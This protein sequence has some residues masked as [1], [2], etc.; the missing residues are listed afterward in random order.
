[1]LGFQW[2]DR[3]GASGDCWEVFKTKPWDV[4]A[5]V[6]LAKELAP[7]RLID[8]D[9]GGGANNQHIGDVNDI[10][11]YPWPGDPQPSAT[12]CKGLGTPRCF[13]SQNPCP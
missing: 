13:A 7:N 10:H 1:M 2:C 8:T 3:F 6:A 4:A 12:Q 5:V 9:S 11:S